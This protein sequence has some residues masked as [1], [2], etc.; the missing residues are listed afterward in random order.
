M[1]LLCGWGLLFW[2]PFAFQY[3]KRLTYLLSMLGIVVS[4]EYPNTASMPQCSN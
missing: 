2:Q 4:D 3:G 1:F